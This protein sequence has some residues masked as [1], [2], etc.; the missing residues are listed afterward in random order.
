M[1]EV[2]LVFTSYN[3]KRALSVLGFDNLMSK[4]EANL[5]AFM[6]FFYQISSKMRLSKQSKFNDEFLLLNI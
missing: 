4:I 1:G 6:V 5:H 2:Y 3:L